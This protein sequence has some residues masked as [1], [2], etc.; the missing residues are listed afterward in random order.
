MIYQVKACPVPVDTEVL[1]A[2][3]ASGTRR[4][5]LFSVRVGLGMRRCSRGGVW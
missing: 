5:L 3:A 4:E 2:S 1:P